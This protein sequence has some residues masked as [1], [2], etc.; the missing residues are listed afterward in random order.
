MKSNKNFEEFMSDFDIVETGKDAKTLKTLVILLLLFA[1]KKN[2]KFES[3]GNHHTFSE[4]QTVKITFL[5]VYFNAEVYVIDANIE[6]EKSVMSFRCY[7]S[8][9]D[10][11]NVI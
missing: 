5:L 9:P 10:L 4:L 3:I 2:I 7:L 1:K 11:C 6:E 8:H